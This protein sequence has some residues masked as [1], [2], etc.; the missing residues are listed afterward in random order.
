MKSFN[1]D[2][3]VLVKML[4][5]SFILMTGAHADVPDFMKDLDVV[6]T[7]MATEVIIGLILLAIWIIAAITAFARSTAYPLKWAAVASIVVVAAPYIGGKELMDWAK[8]T[9]DA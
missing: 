8:T 5:L 7:E 3:S 1:F 4:F 9:F 2:K 6:F